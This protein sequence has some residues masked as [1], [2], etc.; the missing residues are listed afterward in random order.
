M[1]TTYNPDRVEHIRLA[2]VWLER[3]TRDGD[4]GPMFLRH[5]A[6]PHRFL[7]FFAERTTKLY[8]V[9]DHNGFW[10]CAWTTPFISDV[11]MLGLW[12]RADRRRQ[13]DSLVAVEST[14]AVLLRA[15]PGMVGA[16]KRRDLVSPESGRMSAHEKMGYRVLCELPPIDE[17]PAWLVGITRE[18]FAKRLSRHIE[19]DGA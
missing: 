3:M 1:L 15:C 5:Y 2:E 7:M 14:Y 12:V 11:K 19:D 6:A 13:R 4:L 16:T 10:L 8:F 17:E 18:W 9:A